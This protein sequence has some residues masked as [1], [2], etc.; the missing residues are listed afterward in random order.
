MFRPHYN[1]QTVSYPSLAF[2]FNEF[3]LL[4]S[5]MYKY[6]IMLSKCTQSIL[7]VFLSSVFVDSAHR[8]HSPLM[9]QA[10]NFHKMERDLIAPLSEVGDSFLLFFWLDHNHFEEFDCDQVV[11]TDCRNSAVGFGFLRPILWCQSSMSMVILFVFLW[12]ISMIDW[13]LD[14]QPFLWYVYIPL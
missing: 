6:I 2:S 13:T 12:K 3:P 5:L 7:L 8:P 4:K 14:V 10:Y 1:T 11:T 9:F